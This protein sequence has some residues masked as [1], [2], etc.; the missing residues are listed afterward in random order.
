MDPNKALETPRNRIQKYVD[1][2]KAE[3]TRRSYQTHLKDFREFC[4]S[5]GYKALPATVMAV[6][7]YLTLLADAGAKYSTIQVKVA[8]VSYAHRMAK[9]DNPTKAVE[10][11]ET[12]RG[13]RRTIDSTQH[14]KEPI[15]LTEVR[16]LMGVLDPDM[17]GIRDR[18][19]LLIGFAGAFRRSE[20]VGLAVADVTFHKDKAT[21]KLQHSKT[22]Q[23]GIGMTKII[24]LVKDKSICPVT[25]LKAWLAIANITEGA[26]FRP[27]DRWG[28][29][30]NYAMT[31]KE[32]AR[33]VKKY[34]Q[35]AEL[36]PDHFSGHS[37]RAG[38]IT[39]AAER[40]VPIWKIKKQTGHKSDATVQRYIRDK[41]HAAEDA[42]KAVFGEDSVED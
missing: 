33:I 21:I 42:T 14:G 19:L 23:E 30:G 36:D 41:N 40:N 16:K 11:Q 18:A 8:A 4:A 34:V 17:R 9:L 24:P 2:S 32:V 5:R 27:I 1:A 7:D 12:L 22:D 25:A 15:T 13:I 39:E 6:I 10:V 38:Y 37:L 31:D 20:L 3:N 35:L 29:M 28:N 26:I